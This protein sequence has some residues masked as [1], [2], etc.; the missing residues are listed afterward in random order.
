MLLGL[1]KSL[2]AQKVYVLSLDQIVNGPA[3]GDDLFMGWRYLASIR[4]DIAIAAL[5]FQRPGGDASFTGITGGPQTAKAVRTA[6]ELPTLPN[7][8]DGVYELRLLSIPG[9][10][11]ECFWLRSQGGGSDW[12]IPFDTVAPGVQEKQFYT[13]N[14]FLTLA[15]PLASAR[16]AADQNRGSHAPLDDP[17][18][19][20]GP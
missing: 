18:P 15:R 3:P 11:T 7:P 6:Q 19:V 4:P 13:M 9:L 12:V 14:A 1:S 17:D 10:L 16:L 20:V 8:P 5:A 2:S